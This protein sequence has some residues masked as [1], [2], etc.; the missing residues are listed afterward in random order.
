MERSVDN[1]QKQEVII[2]SVE[3]GNNIFFNI[4]NINENYK[5]SLQCEIDI[6]H[7]TF[8]ARNIVVKKEFVRQGFGSQLFVEAIKYSRE[9]NLKFVTDY[10]ISEDAERLIQYLVSK[11]Y[12]FIKNPN[13]TKKQSSI[14]KRI[15]TSDGSPVY[16]LEDKK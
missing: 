3:E 4:P 6:E 2:K 7:K 10:G 15:V 1:T 13:A 11:G 16:I 5:A 14:G 8:T 12:M 9:H